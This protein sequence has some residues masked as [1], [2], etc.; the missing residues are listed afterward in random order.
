MGVLWIRR[1]R[2][3][4]YGLNEHIT[5]MQFETIL[6]L[7]HEI[8]QAKTMLQ[9]SQMQILKAGFGFK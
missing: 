1:R 8:E 3:S 6:M 9:V 7:D 5:P 4:G 2:D